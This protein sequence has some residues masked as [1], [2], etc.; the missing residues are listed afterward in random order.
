MLIG[1]WDEKDRRRLGMFESTDR[2]T[3]L[4]QIA[5]VGTGTGGFPNS[6]TRMG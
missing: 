5:E 2:L 1:S 4:T 6:T 3:F